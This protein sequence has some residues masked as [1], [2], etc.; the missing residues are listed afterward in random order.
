LEEELQTQLHASGIVALIRQVGDLS[1]VRIRRRGD[2]AAR[3]RVTRCRGQP[4][5]IKEVGQFSS[6]LNAH[7]LLDSGVLDYR[8]VHVVRGLNSQVRESKREC[9]DVVGQLE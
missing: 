4:R 8:E 7:P 3:S 5:M 6:E 1:K 9:A 2:H